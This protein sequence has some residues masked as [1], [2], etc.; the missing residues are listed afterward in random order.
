M[1]RSKASKK[2]RAGATLFELKYIGLCTPGAAEVRATTCEL[3]HLCILT[4]AG[5]G[6][7][8]GTFVCT[9]GYST[10]VRVGAITRELHRAIIK[11]RYLT[12][13]RGG[14][15][16]YKYCCMHAHLVEAEVGEFL[17]C[18]DRGSREKQQCREGVEV[19]DGLDDLPRDA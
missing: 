6:K 14:Q 13:A 17:A 9:P 11:A 1:Q 12:R 5:V 8:H 10:Q 7:I 16:S 15:A 2:D 19:P 18:R 3:P 4:Q